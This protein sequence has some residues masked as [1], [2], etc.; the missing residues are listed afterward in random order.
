MN[1]V[2]KCPVCGFDANEEYPAPDVKELIKQK[3]GIKQYVHD[4]GGAAITIGDKSFRLSAMCNHCDNEKIKETL[5][6]G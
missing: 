3:G 5:R 2:V 4:P 1:E 6:N